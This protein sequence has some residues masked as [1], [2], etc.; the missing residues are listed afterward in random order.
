[1]QALYMA[2]NVN[3]ITNYQA[4]FIK[5][6]KNELTSTAFYKYLQALCSTHFRGNTV[7]LC[8]KVLQPIFIVI[9]LNI[10]YRYVIVEINRVLFQFFFSWW[11]GVGNLIIL[12][13]ARLHIAQSF[14]EKVYSYIPKI[15]MC[16]KFVHTS[17]PWLVPHPWTVIHVLNTFHTQPV[18]RFI[19]CFS[20]GTICK[21]FW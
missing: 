14:A 21:L 12:E 9:L 16:H 7:Q 15:L 4:F 2:W 3:L 1:M 8:I 5:G 17:G 20:E 18:I 13:I 10:T 11:N 19:V 6:F